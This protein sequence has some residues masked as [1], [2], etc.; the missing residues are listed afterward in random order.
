MEVSGQLRSPAALP[1]W[2]D[3]RLVGPQSWS[4]RCGEENNFA[5]PGIEPGP[6][7]PSLLGLSYPGSFPTFTGLMLQLCHDRFLPY[8]FH[9]PAI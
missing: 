2:K 3:W 9:Y 8:P 6:S 5:L 7:S 4:G 1:P